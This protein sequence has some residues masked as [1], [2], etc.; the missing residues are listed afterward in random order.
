VSGKICTGPILHAGGAHALLDPSAPTRLLALLNLSPE[1]VPLGGPV[2]LT[3]L[4]LS[5]L[6]RSQVERWSSE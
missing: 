3:Q 6:G 2:A 1:F 4:T 5:R